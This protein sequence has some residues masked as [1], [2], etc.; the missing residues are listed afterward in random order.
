MGLTFASGEGFGAMV[1]F[2][3]GCFSFVRFSSYLLDSIGVEFSNAISVLVEIS[4]K[5]ALTQ[6]DRAGMVLLTNTL[7]KAIDKSMS[8]ALS[9]FLPTGT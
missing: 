3:I 9:I 7:E 8:C 2:S 6:H 1:M 5:T 4:L